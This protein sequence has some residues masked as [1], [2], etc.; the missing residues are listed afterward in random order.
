MGG[1]LLQRP[2]FMD[3]AFGIP[4]RP[5]GVYDICRI[6]RI[7]FFKAFFSGRVEHLRIGLL[8]DQQPA[9]AVL[10]DILFSFAR[11]SLLHDHIRRSGSPHAN[12]R[13]GD[14]DSAGKI[15][16]DKIFTGNPP[17]RQIAID[18]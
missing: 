14:V 10:I 12:G 1:I 17:V 3:H 18:S 2:V 11:G 8:I 15:D 5:R 9:S 16:H 6:M 13:H 4:G 7:C